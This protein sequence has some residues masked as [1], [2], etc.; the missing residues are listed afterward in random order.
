[1]ENALHLFTITNDHHYKYLSLSGSHK[2]GFAGRPNNTDRRRSLEWL[3]VSKDMRPAILRTLEGS[4][5]T[6]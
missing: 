5:R 6:A 2:G 3:H 4:T 1:M